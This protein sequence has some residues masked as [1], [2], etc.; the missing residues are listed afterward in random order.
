M[1]THSRF[2]LFLA[3]LI[4]STLLAAC[5]G[6]GGGGGGDGD[7]PNPP[8]QQNVTISGTGTIGSSIAG[9]VTIFKVAPDGNID[10]QNPYT[11]PTAT[12]ENK[13]YS[14]SFA[15]NEGDTALI[16]LTTNNLT[17]LKCALQLC[18]SGN[19]NVKFG[20]EYT[21]NP[22]ITLGGI[23]QIKRV[24]ETSTNSIAITRAENENISLTANLSA[25]TDIAAALAQ[26]QLQSGSTTNLGD[27][28]IAANALVAGR[29]G[30]TDNNL[31]RIPAVDLSSA[32]AINAASSQELETS[33]KAASAVYTSLANGKGSDIS[34]ALDALKFDYLTAGLADKGDENTPES[35]VTI[36]EIYNSALSLLDT[37]AA[38]NQ[39]VNTTT[40][41]YPTAKQSITTQKTDKEMNGTTI[42]TQGSVPTDIG[43]NGLQAA[44][45]MVKQIRDLNASSVFTGERAFAEK[46]DAAAK[47]A[48]PDMDNFAYALEQTLIAL[49]NA[50]TAYQDNNATETYTDANGVAVSINTT[51]DSVTY[52]IDHTIYNPDSATP[53]NV[54]LTITDI[55]SVVEDNGSSTNIGGDDFIEDRQFDAQVKLHIAGLLTTDG[56]TLAIRDND[57]NIEQQSHIIFTFSETHAGESVSND[58]GY[59]ETESYSATI[60]NSDA[61]LSVALDVP[62]SAS[63]SAVHFDGFLAFSLNNASSTDEASYTYTDNPFSEQE[64]ED[65][66]T[67]IN[68]LEIKLGGGIATSTESFNVAMTLELNGSMDCIAG[69]ESQF[70]NNEFTYTENNCDDDP[71]GTRSLSGALDF[72]LTFEA[73][74]IPDTVQLHVSAA[75]SAS[76]TGQNNQVSGE[77]NTTFTYDSGKRL[78]LVY[79]SSNQYSASLTNHNDVVITIN[80]SEDANGENHYNGVITQMG[81]QYATISDSS[82]ALIVRFSDGTFESFGF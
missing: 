78:T 18:Q 81:T 50:Y 17:K 25:L 55:G 47:L 68:A 70:I 30:I 77:L 33:L 27:V 29:L 67:S 35:D 11:P 65:I 9:V 45:E 26:Q 3:P 5:G 22:S 57:Q 61:R 15:G 60:S 44:K 62:A 71:S 7:G 41:A 32:D 34:S 66:N 28:A 21:P 2:R 36:A 74:G 58:N 80:E 69:Y 53:T 39:N 10:R 46:I 12:D 40:G 13:R 37:I 43:S 51:G 20:D 54:D 64:V 76:Y 19:S 14:I 4:I 63:T 75:G 1:D 49:E 52:S 72:I 73:A 31:L 24:A 56:A 48:S 79:T 6:G 42:K 16:E 38:N 8:L 82:G 23:I 59:E